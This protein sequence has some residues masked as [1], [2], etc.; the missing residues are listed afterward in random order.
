MKEREKNNQRK[1][2]RVSVYVQY[3]FFC[4]FRDAFS[5]KYF[6]EGEKIAGYPAL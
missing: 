3:E 1:K 5:P 2:G 4:K 6:D